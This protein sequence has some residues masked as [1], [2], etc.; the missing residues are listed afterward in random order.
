MNSAP[1]STN[2]LLYFRG[3][4]LGDKTITK[5]PDG[6]FAF[7]IIKSKN[8]PKLPKD[9]ETQK[10]IQELD[11]AMAISLSSALSTAFITSLPMCAWWLKA[12]EGPDSPRFVVIC[13]GLVQVEH[14]YVH[15]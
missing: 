4:F 15:Q 7:T 10:L 6:M 8:G 11:E 9:E 5:C 12:R 2:P 13:G 1:D 14:C 3:L